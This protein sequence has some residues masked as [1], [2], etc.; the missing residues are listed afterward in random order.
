MRGE[1]YDYR[2]PRRSAELHLTVLR[3]YDHDVAAFLPPGK[4][5]G[6]GSSLTG[7]IDASLKADE[8]K[9][10]T[11]GELRLNQIVLDLVSFLQPL[12]VLQGHV[13]WRGQAGKFTISQGQLS[14]GALTGEGRF[15]RIEPLHIELAVHFTDLDLEAALALD[16][17]HQKEAEAS[18]TIGSVVQAEFT[19]DRLSYKSLRA[20]DFRLT[21]HWHD[22][23]ADLT[24]AGV[25]IAGGQM[26]GQA[27]VWPDRQ[28]VFLAPQLTK[29]DVSHFL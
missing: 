13:A 20:E 21:C 12:E 22:R 10:H 15:R 19:G 29:V 11:A 24:V 27:V 1:V 6:R 3:A 26:E 23:Q 7:H 17:S 28:A 18:P 8:R 25:H 16:T 14:G 4:V 9:L 2:S 5:L